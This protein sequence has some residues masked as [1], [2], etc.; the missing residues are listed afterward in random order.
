MVVQDSWFSWHSSLRTGPSLFGLGSS[1]LC[2][3]RTFFL[4]L[5]CGFFFF[6]WRNYSFVYCMEI[7]LACAWKKM[8]VARWTT[9]KVEPILGE[10]NTESKG[11]GAW[12]SMV[13][14]WLRQLSLDRGCNHETSDRDVSDGCGWPKRAMEDLGGMSLMSMT[15]VEDQPRQG[16][17]DELRGSMGWEI[18]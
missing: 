15:L 12:L 17:L 13:S 6:F 5:F 4:D 9:R 8:Y 14:L 7:R 3:M 18:S 10:G 16:R 2:C 11:L 1:W